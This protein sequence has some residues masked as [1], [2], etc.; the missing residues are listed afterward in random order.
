MVAVRAARVEEGVRAPYRTPQ[1]RRPRRSAHRACLAPALVG[2]P[3]RRM[4]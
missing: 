2:M 3:S 4:R 1:K